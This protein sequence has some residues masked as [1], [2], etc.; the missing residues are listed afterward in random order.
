[1]IHTRIDVQEDK[2]VRVERYVPTGFN[3]GESISISLR[4]IT[5]ADIHALSIVHVSSP[6]LEML[7]GNPEISLMDV[8][9]GTVNHFEYVV[10]SD[11][12][13]TFHLQDDIYVQP[14]DDDST[15]LSSTSILSTGF[16][17]TK[18][19]AQQFSLERWINPASAG[20]GDEFAIT[21]RITAKDNLLQTDV[22]EALPS[23]LTLTKGQADLSIAELVNGQQH[24]HTYSVR[25]DD[26]TGIFEITGKAYVEDATSSGGT[27]E[28]VTPFYVFPHIAINALKE[29]AWKSEVRPRLISVV[30]SDVINQHLFLANGLRLVEERLNVSVAPAI[31]PLV[32]RN[33]FMPEASGIDANIGGVVKPDEFLDIAQGDK[34]IYPVEEV[35][36]L[37][38]DDCNEADDC[39]DFEVLNEYP[40][41]N[42]AN[43]VSN[44]ALGSNYDTTLQ[45]E[46][47]VFNLGMRL[48]VNELR[49]TNQDRYTQRLPFGSVTAFIESVEVPVIRP[50][51][52][53]GQVFADVRGNF[54]YRAT[55]LWAF[56]M[57]SR[58]RASLRFDNIGVALTQTPGGI[59]TGIKIILTALSL[60]VL[61]LNIGGIIG[62]LLRLVV[63]PILRF[64]IWIALRF[65]RT[66]DVPIWPLVDAFV[67]LG[68][69]YGGGSPLLTALADSVVLATDF[70]PHDNSGVPASLGS[71]IPSS[72]N[73]GVAVNERLLNQ[74]VAIGISK[75]YLPKGARLGSIKLSLNYIGVYLLPGILGINGALT[76]KRDGCLCGVKARI[77]F[78]AEIMPR[79]ETDQTLTS[80]LLIMPGAS[81]EPVVF[82]PT[83]NDKT[84]VGELGLDCLQ[85]IQVMASADL[86]AFPTL[87]SATP[88]LNVTIDGEGPHTATLASV[89]TDIAQAG[90]LLQD[91]IR[92]AHASTAFSMAQV[93]IA[94][95]TLVVI[96][97]EAIL[98]GTGN[99]AFAA[100][101]ADASTVGELGLNLAQQTSGYISADL[102]AFP[103]LSSASPEVDVV[104]GIDGPYTLSL[105]PAPSDLTQ[106]EA[107]LGNV[108]RSA[109][110]SP[111]FAQSQVSQV[112]MT[113]PAIAFNFNVDVQAKIEVGG[114]M[115]VTL[116]LTFGV[117]LLSLW[118]MLNNI[119]SNKLNEI[120]AEV[121]SQILNRSLPAQAGPVSLDI[122]GLSPLGPLG[123]QLELSLTGTGIV[124]LLPFSCVPLSLQQTTANEQLINVAYNK[125]SIEVDEQEIRLGVGLN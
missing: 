48:F 40:E 13:G 17:Y 83:P 115:G 84:T 79:I 117:L 100:S 111:G 11:G 89:P 38:E 92:N 56:L 2:W 102:S 75:G 81:G 106:L 85:S 21:L 73:I 120:I 8:L 51:S 37:G 123:L 88:S 50:S 63:P 86:S 96:S 1:M 4:V 108:L 122:G 62:W 71:I 31:R 113:S 69:S 58:G 24:T 94:G 25:A 74:L 125:R 45:V 76:A 3:P 114:F 53:P 67:K 36:L 7:D 116:W 72:A 32:S 80:R 109:S 118:A 44:V 30:N 78:N 33:F 28:N 93:R 65:L 68:L 42:V 97:G 19:D 18:E 20:P 98:S 107:V 60:G 121:G 22:S 15:M 91:A 59:P 82:H 39:F 110:N 124:S 12:P 6:G 87:T 112:T 26:N 23:N 34:T 105:G 95:N 64:G 54:G 70:K 47:E 41:E 57:G 55:G 43:A 119:F 61:N 10:Q 103:T 46:R 99:I 27:T 104:I 14:P 9:E 52:P 77:R 35:T 66:V 49:L 101:P 90:A 16:V 29:P 5:R